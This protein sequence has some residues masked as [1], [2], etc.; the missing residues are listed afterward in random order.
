MKVFICH[1]CLRKLGR[2]HSRSIVGIVNWSTYTKTPCNFAVNG[3]PEEGFDGS[4]IDRSSFHKVLK[5]EKQTFL[6]EFKIK[7]R[8]RTLFID[9]TPAAIG[10]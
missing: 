8:L 5:L 1:S 4:N 7:Q 2:S 10:C 6:F 9:I 3:R